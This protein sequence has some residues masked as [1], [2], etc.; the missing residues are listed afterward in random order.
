MLD[1][2]FLLVKEHAG[3]AIVNNT[4]IPDVHNNAAIQ[5]VSS[6]IF[7]GLKDQVMQ[8]NVQQVSSLFQGNASSIS[9]HPVVTQL[10]SSVAGNFASKFGIPQSTAQNVAYRL[11]PAVIGKLVSKTN[12]PSDNDFDIQSMLNSFGGN[13]DIGAILNQF[14]GNNS[15]QGTLGGLGSALGKL[16]G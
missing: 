8:G 3:D 12:D 15:N 4:E 14:T 5:E 2:L 9:S 16:F 11:V 6:Q 10:I 1:Q 13:V 7:N